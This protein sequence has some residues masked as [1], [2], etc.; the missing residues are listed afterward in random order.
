MTCL[1][2][3]LRIMVSHEFGEAAKHA[4]QRRIQ[5]RL[6][7][8]LPTGMQH[9]SRSQYF[10]DILALDLPDNLPSAVRYLE[11]AKL[12]IR[13][14]GTRMDALPELDKIIGYLGGGK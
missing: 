14:A 5:W 7:H 4:H 3:S 13:M 1:E 2:S 6:A 9:Y 8:N 12:R 11:E 10:R